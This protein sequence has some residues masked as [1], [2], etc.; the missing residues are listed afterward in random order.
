MA[1]R[2]S[3]DTAVGIRKDRLSFVTYFGNLVAEK[4]ILFDTTGIETSD[5]KTHTPKTH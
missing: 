2:K 4:T 1:R 3:R 5:R